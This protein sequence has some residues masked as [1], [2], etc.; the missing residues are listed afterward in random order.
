MYKCQHASIRLWI[1]VQ[2]LPPALGRDLDDDDASCQGFCAIEGFIS[3][4]D[5]VFR[6]AEGATVMKKANKLSGVKKTTQKGSAT[7]TSS[8]TKPKR[9]KAQ[10]QGELNREGA[11]LALSAER[12]AQTADR[13]AEAIYRNSPT[14]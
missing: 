4:H 2:L 3:R 8:S 13:L 10:G 11:Q 14:G 7:K 6:D 9:R 12:L 5:P 1:L